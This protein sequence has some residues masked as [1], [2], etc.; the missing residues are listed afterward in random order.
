MGFEML[1]EVS[2]VRVNVA[3]SAPPSSEAADPTQL[4]ITDTQFASVSVPT[5]CM[6]TLGWLRV[7]GNV[8]AQFQ[9]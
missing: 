1:R 5:E 6:S 2:A 4:S 3:A 8:Y 9:Q 7:V